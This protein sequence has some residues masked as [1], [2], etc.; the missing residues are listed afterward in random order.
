MLFFWI[1]LLQPPVQK[2]MRA[3]EDGKVYITL[4]AK[5]LRSAIGDAW[6]Q[7][8]FKVQ[9]SVFKDSTCMAGRRLAAKQGPWAADVIASEVITAAA[10]WPSFPELVAVYAS[11]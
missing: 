3:T 1:Y 11:P 8:G 6:K 9:L 2:M 5:L 4:P 10:C 7:A